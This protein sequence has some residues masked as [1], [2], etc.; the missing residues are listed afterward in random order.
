MLRL[1]ILDNLHERQLVYEFASSYV[2][3]IKAL[4]RAMTQAI[5]MQDQDTIDQVKANLAGAHK[6]LA[7]YIV[8]NIGTLKP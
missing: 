4:D 3:D 6:A 2:N 1:T 7:R 5:E 8:L